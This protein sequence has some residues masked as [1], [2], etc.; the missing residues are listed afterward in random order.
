M[1]K[2]D[3]R[4]NGITNE[5][6]NER[7]DTTITIYRPV[8]KVGGITKESSSGDHRN[9]CFPKWKKCEDRI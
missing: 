9:P 2:C 4:T 1:Q 3:G 5:R 6:K 8:F 7:T